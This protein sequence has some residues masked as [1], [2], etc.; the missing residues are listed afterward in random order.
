[1]YIAGVI[2]VINTPSI[3][4]MF[5]LNVQT[6]RLSRTGEYNYE[7]LLM[8]VLN[9]LMI[10]NILYVKYDLYVFL[11][12][13]PHFMT[14]TSI[15]VHLFPFMLCGVRKA[16]MGWSYTMCRNMCV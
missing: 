6:W 11:L 5:K 1:M 2:R 10:S 7:E 16:I 14:N 9:A 12:G 15:P 13:W 4:T 3:L 8:F